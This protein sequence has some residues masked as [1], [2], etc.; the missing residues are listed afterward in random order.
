[1]SEHFKILFLV[2]ELT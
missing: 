2:H 1:V